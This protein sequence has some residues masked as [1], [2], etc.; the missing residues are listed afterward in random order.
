MKNFSGRPSAGQGGLRYRLAVAFS[1]MSLIPLLVLVYL[2]IN[3]VFPQLNVITDISI[4]VFLAIVLSLLGFILARRIVEPVI[5]IAADTKLIANG[6]YDRQIAVSGDD[7]LATLAN[8]INAMSQ[9]IKSNLDELKVYG[10]K[11]REINTE[12]HKRV[13]VLSNLLQITDIISATSM[14]LKDVLGLVVAKVAQ[15]Y[16]NGFC[17][18]LLE[19]ESSGRYVPVVSNSLQDEA[20]EGMTIEEGEGLLGKALFTRSSVVIDSSTKDTSEARR[21]KEACGIN[22]IIAFPLYSGKN[23]FGMLLSGNRADGYS[24]SS[25]DLDVVK[26]F[27]KQITIAIEN[28]MLLKRAKSLTM[29]DDLTDLFNT[30]YILPRLDEEIKRAIFYQRPCSFLIFN[31]DDYKAFRELNGQIASEEMLKK[32]AAVLKGYEGQFGKAARLDADEFALLLP[33]NNK[34][35]ALDVAEEIR[36]KVESSRFVDSQKRPLTVSVGVSEN[37]IDG[38]IGKELFKKAKEALARAKAKGKNRVSG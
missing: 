35:E 12:I 8:S 9:K 6:Q 1:L 37:P 13:V 20:L 17:A 15:L 33:E 24:F 27:A 16:D 23:T 32:V 38:S 5:G 22:N 26:I 2:V 30:N 21:L 34:R 11:T 31:I 3:Y 29:K 7:E 14:E 10:Q 28:D 18:L 4:V 19:K 25:D 36:K